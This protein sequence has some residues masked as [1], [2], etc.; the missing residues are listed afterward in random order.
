MKFQKE[1]ANLSSVSKHLIVK[2]AGHAIHIDQ[3][4][5]VVEAISSMLRMVQDLPS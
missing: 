4:Q 3:P 5:A 2:E 1:L